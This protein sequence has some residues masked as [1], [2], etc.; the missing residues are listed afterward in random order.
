M[1]FSIEFYRTVGGRIPVQDFL[2]ALKASDPDD[3]AV[4]L[5]GLTRLKHRQ[6][7][8]APLSKPIGNG[9]FEFRH[10]GKLNTRI[11]Y[12]FMVGRRIILAH[13]VRNKA[14]KIGKRDKRLVLER[15]R[16][17]LNRHE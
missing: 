8:R 10:V 14:Q 3:F 17:W 11:L 7:H 5:A 12:F 15:K 2:D 1:E 16:D 6:Y 13:G 4:V 9:L